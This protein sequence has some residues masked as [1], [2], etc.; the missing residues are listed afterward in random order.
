MRILVVSDSHR[1]YFSLRKVVMSQSQAEIIFHLG[2]GENDVETLKL[3]FPHKHIIA[4]RG[5]CDYPSTFNISEVFTVEGIKI[6]AT[7]GHEYYVK[8]GYEEVI[9]EGKKQNA[10]IV[11]F[12]HTHLP[13]EN[14]I[15]EMYILNPGSVKGYKGT[16]ATIDITKQGIVTNIITL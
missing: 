2:D 13:Y 9:N 10:N 12:G 1:D 4:V 16:Y 5:N 7:H 11:L 3:E 8:S 14:Y 15:D 6:F